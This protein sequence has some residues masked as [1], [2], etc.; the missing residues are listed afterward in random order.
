MAGDRSPALRGSLLPPCYATFLSLLGESKL[1]L[2]Y[3]KYLWI[4]DMIGWFVGLKSKSLPDSRE[5]RVCRSIGSL[6]VE[7]RDPGSW[8]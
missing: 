7:A 4:I 1:D 3:L 8:V 2:K 5:A 6:P